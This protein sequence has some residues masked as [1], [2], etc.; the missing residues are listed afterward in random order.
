MKILFVLTSVMVVLFLAAPNTVEAQKRKAATPIEATVN[1]ALMYRLTM[2]SGGALLLTSFRKTNGYERGYG[3]YVIEWQAEILFE[4][5][6]YKPGNAIIGYWQDFR[7]LQQQ[8]GTLDSLVVG[9]TIH[10]N[11]G[12]RIRLTGDSVLRKTEQGW[13]IE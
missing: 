9:N 5:E 11:K 3:L 2:E 1:A 4:Q 7:V 6:G 13:R 10:F 12:A 8:P